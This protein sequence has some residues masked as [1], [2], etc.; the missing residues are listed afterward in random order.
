MYKIIVTMMTLLALF[1][2][3]NLFAADAPDNTVKQSIITQKPQTKGQYPSVVIYTLTTC[4]HCKEAK[5]YLIDA[6]IPFINR[7]VDID[8]NH[9]NEL[10]KIY[11]EMGVPDIKRGVPLLVIGDRIRLQGFSKERFENAVKEAQEKT[12]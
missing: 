6:K 1:F 9:Y 2:A 10:I 8:D 12:R 4:P 7:E 11:D 5:Q 3:G